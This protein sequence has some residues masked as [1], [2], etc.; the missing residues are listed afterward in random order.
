MQ[1]SANNLNW[2]AAS[3]EVFAWFSQLGLGETRGF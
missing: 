2:R 1:I 3:S